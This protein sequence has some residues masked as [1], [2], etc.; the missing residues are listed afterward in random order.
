M[1]KLIEKLLRKLRYERES[2]R[3]A[4]EGLAELKREIAEAK[5]EQAARELDR[6]FCP[7][8]CGGRDTTDWTVQ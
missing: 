5:R 6:H 1:M 4:M 2:Y 7:C 8:Q 3:I